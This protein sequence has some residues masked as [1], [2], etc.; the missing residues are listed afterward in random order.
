M[1]NEQSKHIN[2]LEGKMMESN[3][4]ELNTFCKQYIA[5][6]FLERASA[7]Y[8]DKALG[9]YLAEIFMAIDEYEKYIDGMDK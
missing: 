3:K 6:G 1:N 8:P 5:Y 9:G 2:E 4:E 7:T